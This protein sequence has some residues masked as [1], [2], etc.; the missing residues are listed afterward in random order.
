MMNWS[1]VGKPMVRR[2]SS[3]CP[4]EATTSPPT[5]SRARANWLRRSSGRESPTRR[6]LRYGHW[7]S[8]RQLQLHL[9]LPGGDAFR[10][11]S[12][13]KIYHL[14]TMAPDLRCAVPWGR[15]PDQSAFLP[16]G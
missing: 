9:L 1:S 5:P 15:N 6:Q 13:G 11:G 7:A 4:G 14:Q 8:P 10:T 12:G 2:S 3:S 16:A